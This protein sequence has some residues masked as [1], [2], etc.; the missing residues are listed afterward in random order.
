MTVRN[1]GPAD[2]TNHLVH[3]FSVKSDGIIYHTG[4][5]KG[6]MGHFVHKIVPSVPGIVSFDTRN[7]EK[8]EKVAPK[9]GNTHLRRRFIDNY[10]QN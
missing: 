10:F 7:K 3:L 1:S 2:W 8:Y 5:L 9:S 6:E 4:N